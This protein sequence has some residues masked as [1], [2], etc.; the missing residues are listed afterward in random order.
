MPFKK[1]DYLKKQE[2]HK[3]VF[4]VPTLRNIT[5]TAPYF[6]DTN[7]TTLEDAI[8]KMAF[9]NLGI[10]LTIKDRDL[11]IAF[12]KSLEGERPVILDM[13]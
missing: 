6:H 12:L 7:A 1:W 11:I 4:K 13:P 5:L 3:N 8:T 10:T 9:Y 2:S